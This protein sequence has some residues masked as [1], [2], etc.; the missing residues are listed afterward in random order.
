MLQKVTEIANKT[1][2]SALT[3]FPDGNAQTRIP[4]KKIRRIKLSG[5]LRYKRNI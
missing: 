3:I 5:I 1:K 2:E 4:P